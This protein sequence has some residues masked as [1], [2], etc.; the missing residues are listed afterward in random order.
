MRSSVFARLMQVFVLVLLVSVLLFTGIFYFT[1]RSVQTENR[2]NAL[3][4][5]AYD[6]AYLAGTMQSTAFESAFGLSSGN[7]REMMLQKLRRVYE[8]YSAYCMVVDR[9]GSITAYFL[10]LLEEHSDLRAGYDPSSIIGSLKKVLMGQEVIE[11]TVSS[12]GPMFTVAVPWISNNRV[13]G[14]VYIQTAAQTVRASYE[15]MALGITGASLLMVALAAG[16]VYALTRRIT[17]PLYDM[18]Q[19]AS[20]LSA[21]D[22]SHSV[23]EKGSR[24]IHDLAVA[25][26]SMSGKLSETERTRRDF[27][28][29]LSHELRSPMTNIQGFVQGM[30]DGT[31]PVEQQRHYL[32]IVLDETRRLTK[33][34]NGLLD[35]SRLENKDGTP[36]TASFD[37]NELIRLVLTACASRIEGKGIDVQLRFEE[38]QQMVLANRDQIEQVLYNLIDNAVK[39]TPDKGMITISVASLTDGRV[40]ITVRDNGIGILP[41]DAPHIFDRFYKADKA[42][43]SG[44]GTGLGLAICKMILNRHGESIRLVDSQEGSA[45]AF[46]L[47]NATSRKEKRP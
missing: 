20:R 45:F 1:L 44:Q 5:Q 9:S 46:T 11:Q 37:I 36:Q 10:S 26:N 13:L 30:M 2:M 42:H 25:F 8:E 34:V 35:L 3:K 32:G 29:N 14:A 21:G 39:F 27:I 6:I 38:E 41:E 16:L 19:T 17:R 23:P 28:A 40:E 47:K 33:L 7:S 31:V 22:F 15:G 4:A 12:S 18:A 43:T 24:E